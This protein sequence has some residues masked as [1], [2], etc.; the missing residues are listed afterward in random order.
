MTKKR[1]SVILIVLTIVA[2]VCCFAGCQDDV[3][4]GELFSANKK[5][6]DPYGREF[7]CVYDID[8]YDTGVYAVGYE[9]EASMMGK[10]M[11]EKNCPDKVLVKKSKD[12]YTLTYYCNNDSF[13]N[14]K[15]ND[16]EAQT[17]D[18]KGAFG[19]LFEV[20]REDLDGK[21][22]MSGYVNLMKRD[23]QFKIIL[24]LNNA[25]LIG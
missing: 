2:A 9:I 15:F 18:E 3:D 14:I 12:G 8:A 4:E 6:T 13:S 7:N 25:I 16:V 17:A 20:T 11:L 19:Y 5:A 10:S 22:E 1:V 24:D 23:V 21:L